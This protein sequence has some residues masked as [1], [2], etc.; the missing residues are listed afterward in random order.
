MPC[1]IHSKTA[2]PLTWAAHVAIVLI[3][4]CNSDTSSTNAAPA[5]AGAPPTGTG[6]SPVGTAA[7]AGAGS[8]ATAGTSA[9]GA[10]GAAGRSDVAGAGAAAASGSGGA[11]ATPTAGTPASAGSG[12]AGAGAEPVA[13]GSGA[14][15][16]SA[17]NLVDCMGGSVEP[18][19][20]ITTSSGTKIDLGPYGSVMDKNM[21]AGF[22]STIA[23]GDSDGGATCAGFTSIRR[24]P[25]RRTCYRP[26]DL[27]FDHVTSTSC[28]RV[29]GES[30]ITGQRHLRQLEATVMLLLF[31]CM[32][33]IVAANSPW[34]SGN[35]GCQGVY[36]ISR[37]PRLGHPYFGAWTPRRSARWSLPGHIAPHRR[38]RCPAQVVI[39]FQRAT[40]HQSVFAVRRYG[41]R[42][43]SSASLI[44][45]SC[46]DQ[47]RSCTPQVAGGLA[48]RPLRYDQRSCHRSTTAWS[49]NALD[50]ATA[51]Y[52]VVSTASLRHS[53]SS[54]AKMACLT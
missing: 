27:K 32:S 46:G 48:A 6:T 18:C 36:Y 2:S 41:H 16:P 40:A 37:P 5:G 44:T 31:A 47:G 45:R 15:E 26:E 23:S 13:A 34:V 39:L 54:T 38:D 9:S 10:A 51:R 22:E 8:L 49:S 17:S 21:G 25:R 30:N 35:G 42:H 1:F 20:S 28:K 19:R 11:T 50:D 53:R 52:F 29:D 14:A 43:P 24:D 33:V 7:G 4:A 12:E 3:V